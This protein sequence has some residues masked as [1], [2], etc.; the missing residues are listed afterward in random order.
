M[1]NSV[2]FFIIGTVLKSMRTALK[3]QFGECKEK[4]KITVWNSFTHIKICTSKSWPMLVTLRQPN[5]RTLDNLLPL[6]FSPIQRTIN[7]SMLNSALSFNQCGLLQRARS[8]IFPQSE[9]IS[10]FE[11]YASATSNGMRSQFL[12]RS[13]IFFFALYLFLLT[14]S[15]T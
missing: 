9:S 15:R 1:D 7:A 8:A 3:N 10:F 13:P 4:A 11:K 2:F 14:A 6:F 12:T 5:E